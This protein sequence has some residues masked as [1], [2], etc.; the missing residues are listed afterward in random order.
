MAESPVS[1]KE[2]GI[3]N[4]RAMFKA[5]MAGKFAVVGTNIQDARY[6]GFV[7]TP[8]ALVRK[9]SEYHDSYANAFFAAQAAT[10]GSLAPRS[11]I[12]AGQFI[13]D[14]ELLRG[15]GDG[16]FD[17]SGRAERDIYLLQGIDSL[18]KNQEG[19]HSC[20]PGKDRQECLS[21]WLKF[22]VNKGQFFHVYLLHIHI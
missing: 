22:L 4:T 21:S 11:P 16:I 14:H 2:L 1:Y 5:A 3:V 9:Q 20:L 6:S 17:M 8:G 19:G 18:Q 10:N 7:V 13:V 12:D 15:E